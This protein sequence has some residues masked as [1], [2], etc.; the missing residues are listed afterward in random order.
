MKQLSGRLRDS[1]GNS[2]R[3]Q[4]GYDRCRMP[5]LIVLE[6]GIDQIQRRKCPHFLTSERLVPW[7]V[8]DR[9]KGKCLSA[10]PTGVGEDVHVERAEL[11][12]PPCHDGAIKAPRGGTAGEQTSAEPVSY[13]VS[14]AV[15]VHWPQVD[16]VL[17]AD[18]AYGA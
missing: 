4:D 11:G 7:R 17:Q 18:Q 14:D 1:G 16:L 12:S 3:W 5:M 9:A 15:D 6:E 10:G 13:D 2:S 8:Q